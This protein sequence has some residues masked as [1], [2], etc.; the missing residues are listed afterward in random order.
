MQTLLFHFRFSVDKSQQAGL[1]SDLSSPGPG[2]AANVNRARCGVNFSC[3]HNGWG[4]FAR[5]LAFHWFR[6]NPPFAFW[7]PCLAK[8][9]VASHEFPCHNRITKT[10]SKGATKT[11]QASR[12]SYRHPFSKKT[13]PCAGSTSP[14][15]RVT[16]RDPEKGLGRGNEGGGSGSGSSPIRPFSFGRSEEQAVRQ[17]KGGAEIQRH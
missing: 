1:A 2:Q 5:V 14:R 7:F 4:S 12:L 9:T 15:W 16:G 10:G 8:N 6:D 11:P 17:T 3:F 13:S